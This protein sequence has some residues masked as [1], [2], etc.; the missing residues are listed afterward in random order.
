M[1]ALRDDV[2]AWRK[3]GWENTSE[4][5]KML[6]RH[7][8]REDRPRQLF[9][10]Q[11]EAVETIIYLNEVLEF[12]RKQ[13]ARPGQEREPPVII[14]VGDNTTIAE[15]F[16]AQVSGEVTVEADEIE[17]EDDDEAVAKW[18]KKPKAVKHYGRGQVFPNL[19]S[20]A[21]GNEVTLRIDSN[22][23]AAAESEDPNATKKE[24]A[25]E[26]RRIVSTV[27]KL[28]TPGEKVRC[29][30][31]VN[32]L[33]EGWDANNVTHILGF[34]RPASVRAGTRYLRASHPRSVA[35]GDRAG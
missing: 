29:V 18:K 6:L 4:V 12:Q 22:L 23:L 13:Q 34:P 14:L 28:G 2:R 9:F 20:N 25:E 35:R 8:S 15:H 30:V 7:W 10:C 11:I 1:N 32:M 19:L 21:K 33:S 3:S 16:H 17:D 24:A 31:S 26:L 5:T 27:G